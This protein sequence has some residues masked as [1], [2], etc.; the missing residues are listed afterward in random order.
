[1]DK[2]LTDAEIKKIHKLCF[3]NPAKACALAQ[4]I[5]DTVGV[6]SCRT[7]ADFK[8][9]STRT[10]QYQAPKIVNIKIENDDISQ[11]WRF[12]TFRIDIQPDGRR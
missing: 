12:G 8:N 10:V 9:K 4:E 7:Y 1:M 5:I 3:A 6:V 2:Q 11:S